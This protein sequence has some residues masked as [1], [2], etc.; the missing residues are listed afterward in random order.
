MHLAI[1]LLLTAFL[2]F[3]TSCVALPPKQPANLSSVQQV[4]V[5]PREIADVLYNPGMGFADFHFGFDHSPA[6]GTYPRS[7][8]AYFRWSWG[9]SRTGGRPVCLRPD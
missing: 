9:R 8:V 3:S 2:L 5:H 7:T 1:P 6:P 4:I